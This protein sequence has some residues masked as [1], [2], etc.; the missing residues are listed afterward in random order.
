M[1]KRRTEGKRMP[2]AFSN[3]LRK[4]PFFA[5]AFAISWKTLIREKS[6][7]NILCADCKINAGKHRRG[8]KL[9]GD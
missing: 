6:D 5:A 1:S 3:R 7:G 8:E 4:L 9:Y 2:K